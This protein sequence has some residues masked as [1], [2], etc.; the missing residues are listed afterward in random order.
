MRGTLEY[1]KQLEQRLKE[2]QERL[3]EA[4]IRKDEAASEGDLKEN[5]SYDIAKNDIEEAEREVSELTSAINNFELVETNHSDYI[6]LGDQVVVQRVFNDGTLGEERRFRV[7]PTGVTIDGFL[8]VKSPLGRAIL[9][10]P[11]GRYE[12][13]GRE[14]CV[15]EVRKV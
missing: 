3:Q 8:S 2:A 6:S 5:V 13:T 14:V 15:Y 4:R 9:D 7:E 11:S 10:N 12:V 1:K